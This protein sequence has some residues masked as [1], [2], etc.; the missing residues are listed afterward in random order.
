MALHDL[1]APGGQTVV[2]DLGA[3]FATTLGVYPE[4]PRGPATWIWCRDGFVV[5]CVSAVADE[6]SVGD[7]IRLARILNAASEIDR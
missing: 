3:P 5:R 4:G 1:N 2:A 6:H 7:A